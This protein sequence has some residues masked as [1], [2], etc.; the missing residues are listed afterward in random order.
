MLTDDDKDWFA[1]ETFGQIAVYEGRIEARL[2]KF[3]AALV[4][5]FHK[6]ALPG[7]NDPRID[8]A[9]LRTID[10]ELEAL[11]GRVEKLEGE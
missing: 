3:E 9:A 11:Q 6:W 7:S 1:G 10:L 8:S 5:E 2:E 4:N